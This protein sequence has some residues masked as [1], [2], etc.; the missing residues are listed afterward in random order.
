VEAAFWFVALS[1]AVSG[2]VLWWLGDETHPRLNPDLC[3]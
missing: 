2:A 1:M 3:E